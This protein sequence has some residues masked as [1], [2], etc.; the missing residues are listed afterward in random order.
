MDKPVE[1]YPLQWPAGF[2]RKNGRSQSQFGGHTLAHVRDT[3]LHQLGLLHRQAHRS[4]VI[5]SNVEL[6]LDGLPYSGRR[7]PEDKGIAVYFQMPLP[8]RSWRDPQQFEWKVF[9][10]DQWNRVECNLW[11]IA[12]TIEAMR[13]IDR[14]GVSDML[15]RA[16]TGFKVPEEGSGRP[17]VDNARTER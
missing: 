14:W 2:S 15:S 11:A 6:R 7:A 10:C 12:K 5:S 1:A 9:A 3:L 17:W 16:F 13:G 4:A 8:Q